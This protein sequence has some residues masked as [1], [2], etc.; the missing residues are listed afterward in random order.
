MEVG[1]G[2]PL[3]LLQIEPVGPVEDERQRV[4]LPASKAARSLDAE[5]GDRRVNVNDVRAQEVPE[6]EGRGPG[7]SSLED[8]DEPGSRGPGPP[9]DAGPR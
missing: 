7:E 4:P 5:V 6:E 9:E 1:L 8:R 2:R 3:L